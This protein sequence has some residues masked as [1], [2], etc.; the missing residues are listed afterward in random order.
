[1]DFSSG[2]PRGEVIAS[3]G[4]DTSSSR[5]ASKRVMEAFPRASP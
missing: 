1:V 2:L 5:A 3:V 4:M